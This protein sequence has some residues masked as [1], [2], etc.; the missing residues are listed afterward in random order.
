MINLNVVGGALFPHTPSQR[1]VSTSDTVPLSSKPQ[2]S[3]P[4]SNEDTEK[5]N[6]SGEPQYNQEALLQQ[7][8]AVLSA[9]KEKNYTALSG[10]VHP[11]KGL[12]LTPYSTVDSTKDRRLSAAELSKSGSNTDLSIWG[13]HD[14]SGFPI[15]LSI[16]DYFDRFVY[17]AEY[18]SAPMLGVNRV[19]SAGNSLENVAAAYPEGEFVE[20]Y[21]PGIEPKNNGFDWCGLKLVFERVAEE[22]KLVGL[23]HSEWTI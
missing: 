4:E 16:Q 7:A 13:L 10:L 22:Y 11:D 18:A 2:S 15:Q 21:I 9:L 1:T 14:G 17:N 8:Y 23:I 3:T 5:A 19:I 12:T 20:F 6:E